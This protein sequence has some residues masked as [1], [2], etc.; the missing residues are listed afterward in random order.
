[1]VYFCLINCVKKQLNDYCHH[2]QLQYIHFNK[3][4]H[5]SIQN[6]KWKDQQVCS[7]SVWKKTKKTF[8]SVVIYSNTEKMI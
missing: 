6:D 2:N 1:M 4:S 8:N 5:K 3:I 7:Y